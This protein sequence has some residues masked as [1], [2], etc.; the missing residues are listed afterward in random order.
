MRKSFFILLLVLPFVAF[1]QQLES[2]KNI[3]SNTYNFW[4]YTPP[5]TPLQD[6]AQITSTDIMAG[7][8]PKP[9]VIF[10]HGASLC[11]SDLSRVRRYGVLHAI[12]MGLDLDAY[13]L[14]PQNPGGA[15]K[16]L[17]INNCLDYVVS[18]YPVDTNRIYVIGMSLGG[19]GTIDYLAVYNQRIAAAMA[20]CGGGNPKDYCG[21][22]NV[23]LWI[24]HGNADRQVSIKSSLKVINAMRRCDDMLPRLIFTELDG[25]NHTFPARLFYLE[26]TYN[27]LFEH[28]R[29]DL[30]RLPNQEYSISTSNMRNAYH[31]LR[32]RGT[33][34]KVV[35][36][37]NSDTRIVYDD[38]AKD[39]DETKATASASASKKKNNAAASSK[40]Q[41]YKV[42]K[43]DTLG[44][45]ARKH[46]TT[47]AKLCKLNGL[48]RNSKLQIGQKI[49][50][51]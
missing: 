35:A 31:M 10:L 1:G 22:N 40:G 21:L 17:Y 44:K 45:I 14:A 5:L 47:I 3:A 25:V 9:L 20:I 29:D 48:N 49:R 50:V 19:Y 11:G 8:T 38:S 28:H 24:V 32:R 36:N 30:V 51:N 33:P 42:K 13:V 37:G 23:P 34:L 26:D 6:S 16:P 18:H 39:N 15:W 43:G 46:G 27:W 2:F 12:Q 7:V 41:I 4:V